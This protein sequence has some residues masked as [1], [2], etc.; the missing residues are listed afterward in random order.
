[1]EVWRF[2]GT[3]DWRRKTEVC[4]SEQNG[5]QKT[6]VGDEISQTVN[7]DETDPDNYRGLTTATEI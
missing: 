4:Q 5:G 2:E 3:E 1:M 7:Y 6:E